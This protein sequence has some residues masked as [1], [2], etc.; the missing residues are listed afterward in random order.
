MA[1]EPMHLI[2]RD[3]GEGF[4]ATSPQAPGLAYGRAT[5]AE[6][7]AEL[8][9]VL[10][11][12]FDRPGPFQ[13][14]EHLER[15]TAVEGGEL[16]TRI[17]TDQHRDQRQEV[18]T[19]LGRALAVP[20]QARSLLEGPA[21]RVGEVVYV[22]AVPSD[23]IGWLAAQLDQHGDAVVVAVAIAEPFVFTV[24]ITSGDDLAQLAGVAIH[25]RGYS[26]Q[27]TVGELV[28]DSPIL[29]PVAAPHPV[30]S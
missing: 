23:T 17:A 9:D 27:T 15:H 8:Q 26:P 13:V 1:D 30:A 5:L 22:C 2:V 10:A 25:E 4:Y 7:R 14:A 18:A 16:V 12:H 6:L 20:G 19:R 28:R 11:F 24:P 21:N 3:T 29:Q